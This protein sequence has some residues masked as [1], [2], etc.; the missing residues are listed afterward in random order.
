M[1][2]NVL[3][4]QFEALFHFE[5]NGCFSVYEVQGL[6]KLHPS[7]LFSLLTVGVGQNKAL[8]SKVKWHGL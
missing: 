8:P 3:Y 6:N 4:V 1:R 2:R 7:R 5:M